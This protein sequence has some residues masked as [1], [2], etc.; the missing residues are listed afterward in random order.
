MWAP[1]TYL[2]DRGE[3]DAVHANIGVEKYFFEA[4]DRILNRIKEHPQHGDPAGAHRARSRTSC[5]RP[6]ATAPTSTGT[7]ATS[8]PTASRPAR[9]GT[10]PTLQGA[11]AA[12]APG[13]PDQPEH[14][15]GF[16]TSSP[17]T[18]LVSAP[19]ART[20]R[21]GRSRGRAAEPAE[22]EPERAV[23]E[24]LANAHPAG[25]RG[26]GRG[27]PDRRRLPARLRDRGQ[28]RG[29]RVRRRQLRPAR[30]G[31][32]VRARRRAAAG[33]D[34]RADGRRGRRSRPR[35][36]G[37]RAVGDPLH[38]R[39]HA[40]RPTTSPL[41]DST[42]PREPGQTF[43]LTETTTFRWI[44]TDIKGNVSLRQGEVQHHGS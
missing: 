43:H 17:A 2:P 21:R 7:T 32:R 23:H 16:S 38:H 25:E 8:S 30:V 13:D 3:G 5:T 9:T 41:W 36:S 20:R 12:G 27:A 1:G 10:S 18:R 31:A 40:S 34:D 44:A 15:P 11:A 6:P 4:G 24:P 14:G 42:G 26:R 39:R 33:P 37:Q 22:P 35:S 29:A 28:V 19:A